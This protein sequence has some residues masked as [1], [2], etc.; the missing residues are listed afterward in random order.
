[1]DKRI[2]KR[3]LDKLV[4]E[5]SVSGEQ[6][7]K[8]A[9]KV[10]KKQNN[11]YYKDVEG[12]M[13]DYDKNLKQEDENQIDPKKTNAEGKEKE[14]HEDME[15]MNGLEMNQYDN[16]PSTA[17][18]DRAKKAIE[19]DATMG[20]DSEWANVI[21]ADQQGF[22][23]PDFGKDLVKKANASKKKRNDSTGTFNQF[24]DDIEMVD[25]ASKISK[26]KLAT[27]TMK[28]IKF[29][30]PLNG[31]GNALKLIPEAFRVD[32]KEFEMT[33][34]NET[35]RMKW[36][37]TLAEGKATVLSAD[38]K[39]LVNE[40]FSKIKHLMGYKAEDTLGT[41]SATDR[42]NENKRLLENAT[43]VGFGTQGNGFT[44]E[45]DLMG[46]AEVVEE[47]EV[48]EETEVV[49]EGVCTCGEATCEECKKKA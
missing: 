5:A 8:K 39:D 2:I 3:E 12:K 49:E 34:G 25:G 44:S 40:D 43:G 36:K 38:S 19:G 11:A 18:K 28:R 42:I 33:D 21:P 30:S 35:Y 14:Y 27:E 9:Q 20:N 1:M 48:M 37:G 41:P 47:V 17:F 31:V 23:G 7:T 13:K 46:D 15:I 26:K 16:E 6:V 24:G 4:A 22:T 10:S 45:G 32:N 29:K